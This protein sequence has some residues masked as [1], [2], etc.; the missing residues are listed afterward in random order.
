MDTKD[1]VQIKAK[2]G[3]VGCVAYPEMKKA[4]GKTGHCEGTLCEQL[5]LACLRGTIWV[6][7]DKNE[8]K[9]A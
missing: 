3:C 6:K 5:G 2:N 7:K 9:Q 8:V 1:L 4:I